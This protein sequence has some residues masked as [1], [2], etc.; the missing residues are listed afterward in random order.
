MRTKKIKFEDYKIGDKVLVIED[1]TS[2]NSKGDVGIITEKLNEDSLKVVV[3]GISDGNNN[4]ANWHNENSIRLIKEN[5]FIK[6]WRRL[7]E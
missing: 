7:N 2:K 1:T 4:Y 3:K 6:L 5:F